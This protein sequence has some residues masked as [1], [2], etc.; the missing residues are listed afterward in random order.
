[1]LIKTRGIVFRTRK[2]SETSIIADIFTEE[3]GMRSYIISGVR[4]KKSKIS[5]GLLQVMTIVDL[6]AYHRDDKD[7]T[8]IKEIKA[9]VIYSTIPF[10]VPRS[11]VGLFMIEIAR[12]TVQGHEAAPELFSFI[13]DNFKYL[14][15][16]KHFSNLHIHF[17]VHLATFSGFQINGAFSDAV[18]YFDLQNGNFTEHL[19]SHPYWLNPELSTLLG[20]FVRIPLERCQEIKLSRPMRKQLLKGLLDYYQLHIERFP[21]VLSHHVLE[22][23]LS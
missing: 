18:P 20:D 9:H 11:A 10:E 22:E 21:E 13:I 1:M 6:V 16:A 5:A 2:Y 3:K 14:D 12:N 17:L 7:L 23:V 4:A 15:S 8:R 19:P